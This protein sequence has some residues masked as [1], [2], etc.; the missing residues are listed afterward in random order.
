MDWLTS[1]PT[2]VLLVTSPLMILLMV[3][4]FARSRSA[5]SVRTKGPER[6][7][8]IAMARAERLGQKSDHQGKKAA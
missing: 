1:L 3:D 8:V 7:R 5:P 4:A 2:L 6:G